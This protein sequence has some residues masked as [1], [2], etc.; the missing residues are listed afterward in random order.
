MVYVQT[1][2]LLSVFSRR[3]RLILI[4]GA[5]LGVLALYQRAALMNFAILQ[6]A[7]NNMHTLVWVCTLAMSQSLIA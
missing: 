5:A 2:V 4:A 3:L 6:N 7:M 1:A